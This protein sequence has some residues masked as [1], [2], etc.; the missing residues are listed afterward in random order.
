MRWQ[1]PLIAEKFSHILVCFWTH[2]E[3]GGFF[4]DFFSNFLTIYYYK[5]LIM[6]YLINYAPSD[7]FDE[8]E[9]KGRRIWDL[10]INGRVID[11]EFTP[12]KYAKVDNLLTGFTKT[13][14][15]E[16]KYRK[17][18][19]TSTMVDEMGGHVLEWNKFTALTIDYKTYE[20]HLYVMIYKDYILMWDVSYV[21]DDMFYWKYYPKTTEGK[22][23]EKTKKYVCD[24]KRKDAICILK[25]I[26]E[27]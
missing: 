20:L 18:K 15:V 2:L 10:I 1:P 24:L 26:Y 9:I 22:N 14:A 3:K 12:D 7:D 8:D 21:N 23:K 25:N 5:M 6:N 19:Y 17:P 27:N 11:S 13:A 4:I 16:L